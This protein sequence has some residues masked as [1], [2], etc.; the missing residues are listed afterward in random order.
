MLII[1]VRYVHMPPKRQQ[2]KDV[3]SPKNLV[4]AIMGYT[5]S[6]FIVKGGLSRVGTPID[7]DS[8]EYSDL[9]WTIVKRLIIQSEQIAYKGWW[10]DR[11][12]IDPITGWHHDNYNVSI[13]PYAYVKLISMQMNSLLITPIR[14]IKMTKNDDLNCAKLII[15]RIHVFKYMKDNEYT[16]DRMWKEMSAAGLF[17][18]ELCKLGI[19]DKERNDK[20]NEWLQSF[21]NNCLKN[22][23]A[24]ATSEL[25]LLL[26]PAMEQ[27]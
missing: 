24:Y 18:P 22:V 4:E 13:L 6:L 1:L 23:Q 3:A 12:S 20:Y 25:L 9:Y 11:Y 19:N 27:L 17:T 16:E 2:T 5:D 14:H 7:R 8:K 10:P 26:D 15:D 21:Q